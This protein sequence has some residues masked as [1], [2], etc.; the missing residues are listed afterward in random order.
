MSKIRTHLLVVFLVLLASSIVLTIMM[1]NTVINSIV[2]GR[3]DWLLKS[4]N[5]EEYKDTLTKFNVKP[6]FITSNALF[7]KVDA[8]IIG[9]III[10]DTNTNT[11]ISK[12]LSESA[13][14]H[15]AAI[16]KDNDSTLTLEHNITLVSNAALSGKY[17]NKVGL[18]GINYAKE[19]S[20][21]Y[22]KWNDKTYHYKI[23]KIAHANEI[24]NLY[25]GTTEYPENT[26]TLVT[27]DTVKLGVT[28]V[29]A[30][31]VEKYEVVPNDIN[32]LF[33]QKVDVTK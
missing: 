4:K 18:T 22:L 8:N 15:T 13:M 10:P 28:G 6:K 21:V 14:D 32:K 7:D 9:Q 27:A 1:N 16:L 2:I 24:R 17:K 20:D 33:N 19:G 30:V 11:P 12:T 31:F 5:N 25:Y 26:L 23:A 3:S 29:K